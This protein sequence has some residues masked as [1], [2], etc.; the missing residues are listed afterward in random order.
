MCVIQYLNWAE[1]P[2]HAERLFKCGDLSLP[3]HF[4][5]RGQRVRSVCRIKVEGKCHTCMVFK[6]FIHEQYLGSNLV[7]WNYAVQQEM[8]HGLR[9][10]PGVRSIWDELRDVNS[11]EWG[12]EDVP[13]P[14][15]TNTAVQSPVASSLPQ[16]STSDVHNP[17]SD[18]PST[19]DN[20]TKSATPSV[21][22]QTAALKTEIPANKVS[23]KAATTVQTPSAP[24]QAQVSA[25][26]ATSLPVHAYSHV[27]SNKTAFQSNNWVQYVPQTSSQMQAGSE[28]PDSPASKLSPAM[29]D[30]MINLHK[31]HQFISCTIPANVR[32][33]NEKS[34][35]SE[36][37]AGDEL[38]L[39]DNQTSKKS[40]DPE[41]PVLRKP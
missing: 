3:K 36:T 34:A 13:E 16:S 15:Q 24:N 11:R 40:L 4:G 2:H 7:D 41:P 5:S 32:A 30:E 6:P 17:N 14:D 21:Q 22:P 28:K 20:A 10:G 23:P 35:P 29:R 27:S 8:D 26:K 18:T 38:I 19:L 12:M 33:V 1:C 39:N 9:V 31:E 25:S 37:L